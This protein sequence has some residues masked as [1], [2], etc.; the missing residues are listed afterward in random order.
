MRLQTLQGEL[1][2]M[3]MKDSEDVSSYITHVQTVA[4][5]LKCNG[6]T[7]TDARVL[8]EILGSLTDVF[9]N[10]VCAIKESRNLEEMTIDD[11]SGSLEAH[12]QRKKNKK[13]VLEEAL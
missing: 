7:L 12:E 13:Q 5:Q 6:E 9:E 10:V 1:E 3:K 11:L 4:N 8:E 2:A